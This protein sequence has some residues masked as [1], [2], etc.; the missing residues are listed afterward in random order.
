[1]L[2]PAASVAEG[3]AGQ[4]A[5]AQHSPLPMTMLSPAVSQVAQSALQPAA[6]QRSPLSELQ[7]SGLE[8]QSPLIDF[9]AVQQRHAAPS[10]GFK[11]SR[12]CEL[13]VA[14]HACSNL[15]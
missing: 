1:M 6:A 11:A 14:T 4:A 8:D 5:A 13:A 12:M 7:L 15:W 9:N 10:P 3:G 2:T